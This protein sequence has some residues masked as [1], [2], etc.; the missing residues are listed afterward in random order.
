MYVLIKL[1]NYVNFIT[2]D[3]HHNVH[4]LTDK[5]QLNLLFKKIGAPPLKL[6]PYGGIEMCVLLLLL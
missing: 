2:I 1:I 4:E 3:E 5:S 6:R